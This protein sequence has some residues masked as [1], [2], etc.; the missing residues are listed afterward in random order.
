MGLLSQSK[1][2]YIALKVLWNWPWIAAQLRKLKLWAE[3]IIRHWNH[4][5]ATALRLCVQNFANRLTRHL[6]I[7]VLLSWDQRQVLKEHLFCTLFDMTK[8]E[9]NPCAQN[10]TPTYGIVSVQ[11][12]KVPTYLNHYIGTCQILTLW[13]F[14]GWKGGTTLGPWVWV[15]MPT[16]RYQCLMGVGNCFLALIVFAKNRKILN[17]DFRKLSAKIRRQASL[18]QMFKVYR[19]L[20]Q[21]KS[22]DND[23]H[24]LPE[25]RCLLD[26]SV[27]LLKPFKVEILSGDSLVVLFHNFVGKSTPCFV[28][29]I[30]LALSFSQQWS[31]LNWSIFFLSD[32]LVFSET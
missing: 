1:R 20:C 25:S 9:I 26:A 8:K 14:D 12:S 13:T 10:V 16:T 23:W 2:H 5:K 30:N 6:N 24:I 19:K 3:A 15:G 17:F 11:C 4:L 22:E 31:D 29:S 28:C 21:L 32:I 18:H 7:D 27:L